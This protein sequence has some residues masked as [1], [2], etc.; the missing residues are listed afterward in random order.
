M[1]FSLN[2]ESVKILPM[3]A[4]DVCSSSLIFW[5]N[6]ESSS[7][8]DWFLLAKFNLFCKSQMMLFI[9]VT[10]LLSFPLKLGSLFLDALFFFGDS[11]IIPYFFELGIIAFNTPVFYNDFCRTCFDLFRAEI[12]DIS[13]FDKSTVIAFVKFLD[14]LV[15]KWFKLVVVLLWEAL[16]GVF[17]CIFSRE[18]FCN[19]VA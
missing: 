4:Y 17:Y 8:C 16:L 5:F 13:L 11:Q 12:L 14:V 1:S 7:S 15:E 10:W 6:F 9:L 3:L 2:F 19:G 18:L